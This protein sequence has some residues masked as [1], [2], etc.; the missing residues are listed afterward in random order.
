VTDQV[1]TDQIET[2]QNA[3]IV[4]VQGQFGE[5]ILEAT[6]EHDQPT[7]VVGRENLVSLATFLRDDPELQFTRFVDICGV[8]YLDINKQKLP[9]RTRFE[10]VYHLHSLVLNCWVRVRVPVE[11]DD[12]EVPSLAG[13]W[14]GANWFERETFDLFGIRFTNHPDPTRILMPDEWEGHPLRKDYQPPKE[15]HEW[16]FNPE[17]WQKAVQRGG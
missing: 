8:D 12:A 1:A 13:L 4:R 7:F 15:P 14:S 10:V 16:S 9:R 3:V 11:E 2:E 5:E 6:V 17:E